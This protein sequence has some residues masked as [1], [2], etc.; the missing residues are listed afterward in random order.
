MADPTGDN[1]LFEHKVDVDHKKQNKEFKCQFCDLNVETRVKLSK[2][3]KRSNY[4][5][6]ASQISECDRSKET[7]EPSTCEYPCFYCGYIIRTKEHL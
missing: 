1:E 6:Q 5:D 4:R 7:R 2:H 3:V